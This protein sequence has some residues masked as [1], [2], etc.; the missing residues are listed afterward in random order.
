MVR[1]GTRCCCLQQ[2]EGSRK[3]ETEAVRTAD[4]LKVEAEVVSA[5]VGDDTYYRV[6]VPVA[7]KSMADLMILRAKVSGWEAWYLPGEFETSGSPTSIQSE[8]ASETPAAE[9]T[10]TAAVSVT[11]PPA[12]DPDPAS[13]SSIDPPPT[14]EDPIE[15]EEE[16]IVVEA[17]EPPMVEEVDIEDEDVDEESPVDPARIST[18]HVLEGS[19]EDG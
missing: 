9:D 11:S 17:D 5:Q 2:L 12:E 10:D 6:L 8:T 15:L 1:L 16:T 4:E 7:T 3:A 18:F 13:D 19:N 14:E